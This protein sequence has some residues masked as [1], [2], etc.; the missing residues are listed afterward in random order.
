MGYELVR[1]HASTWRGRSRRLAGR[2]I[3]SRCRS[4]FLWCI[5]R[6]DS[7]RLS[8]RQHKAAAGVGL[9]SFTLDY[10]FTYYAEKYVVSGIV[11]VVFAALAF[12][13]LSSSSVSC[14]DSERR[15]A[16]GSQPQLESSA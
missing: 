3:Q 1:A 11:A 15:E 2:S 8:L 9:F 13:N 6:G 7:V 5:F 12:V 4:P 14:W 10:S 16:P